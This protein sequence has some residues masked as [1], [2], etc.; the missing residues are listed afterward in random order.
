MNAGG[1]EGFAKGAKV[2][3]RSFAFN[4]VVFAFGFLLKG[5]GNQ[6]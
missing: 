2:P 4:F 3:W 1:R 5:F 6:L